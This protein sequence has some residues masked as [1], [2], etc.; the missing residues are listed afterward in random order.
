M[1]RTNKKKNMK[2]TTTTVISLL[3]LSFATNLATARDQ[4]RG[5]DHHF[6][7]AREYD[8]DDNRGCR[9]DRRCVSAPEIDPGQGLGAL[10]LLGGTVAIFRGFRRRK[11]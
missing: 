10:T 6:T 1:P 5:D 2:K 4:Y 8:R 11:K 7:S 3:L 9:G